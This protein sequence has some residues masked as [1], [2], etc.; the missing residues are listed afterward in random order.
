[1]IAMSAAEDEF[2]LKWHDHHQ[3]F[4]L[5]VEELVMR[6]QLTD[7]TLACGHNEE[8]QLLSAHSLML[9]VCSPYFRT[10]LS[11]NRH[12]EKHHIIHLHGVSSRHMQQLLVYIY[13]GEISISQD[14]LGPLIETA[15]CLQIK[16]LAMA[17]PNV[18]IVQPS[19][20]KK[21]SFSQMS[22]TGESSNSIFPQSIP[23][24]LNNKNSKKSSKNK[25][26]R[27]DRPVS[28]P[29]SVPMPED[30]LNSSHE[31][32]EALKG[33]SQPEPRGEGG[34][35]S[36]YC[37]MAEYSNS[38]LVG[39]GHTDPFY[40]SK[41]SIGGQLSPMGVTLPL[42]PKPLSIL[43]TAE[44]RTYLSKLIW[45]GNGGRRPQYGNPETKPS[46]WPQ[47]ILPWED[48]KKMGGRKSVELSHINYTEILK[49][50]LAAG[51][52]YFG[53]DPA[54]Y[55]SSDAD[56]NSFNQDSSFI[57]EDGHGTMSITDE[58]QEG[59]ESRGERQEQPVLEIDLDQVED[60]CGKNVR[61]SEQN[62]ILCK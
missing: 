52:E 58:S 19:T 26:L 53:Y 38:S 28:P 24:Q 15:R 22:P 30:S 47:H 11:E 3:S 41:G 23:A 61:R 4:F 54:T 7:V 13:R 12:K 35:V 14:D 10:L 39:V 25:S 55:F 44:T 60:G 9:S 1:M 21:R 57:N 59:R 49:Q 8:H 20:P 40:S 36:D 51:Y 2:L 45:L 62:Q 50:C 34:E 5:L 6:E 29:T 33:E 18:N 32:L 37:N 43:K 48:M 27:L 56:E 17:Q 46:W 42:L 16:G 31:S